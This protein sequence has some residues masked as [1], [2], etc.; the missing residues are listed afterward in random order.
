MDSNQLKYM[1]EAAMLAAGQPMAIDRLQSL[2]SDGEP[3]AKQAIRAA[4]MELQSDYADRGIEVAEVGS[5]FRVQIRTSMAHQLD[6][7]WDERPPR[8]SRARAARAS[9]RARPGSVGAEP[10]R[11]RARACV[12]RWSK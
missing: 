1:I 4:I 2:F 8:Y 5:G 3:P 10:S 11:T 6:K 7:L 9:S 12:V